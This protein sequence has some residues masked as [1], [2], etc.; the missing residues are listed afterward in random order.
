MKRLILIASLA[1]LAACAESDPDAT[2]DAADTETAA[3]EEAAVFAADGQPPEGAYKITT[4]DG[5][6]FMEELKPDGTYVQTSEDGEVVE[7]GSWDQKSPEQFC[8]TADAEYVDED[9][10]AE[11]QCN[12]EALGEDGVWTSTG[13]DGEAVTVERVES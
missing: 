5:T 13:S 12:T 10:P 4:A 3:T 11:E 1:G 2:A 8:F 7:T 6:V 9:T